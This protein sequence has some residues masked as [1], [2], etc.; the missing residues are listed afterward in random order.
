M[1]RT[2]CSFSDTFL[3]TPYS[4]LRLSTFCCFCY[5]SEKG[6]LFPTHSKTSE[7]FFSPLIIIMTSAEGE[8]T[9]GFSE[10]S[11]NL[12]NSLKFE[13]RLPS[14]KETLQLRMEKNWTQ[15]NCSLLSKEL[16]S[17]KL[18]VTLVT[19]VCLYSREVE[20]R[21]SAPSRLETLQFPES[22]EQ[23]LCVITWNIL[24]SPIL[25]P[26]LYWY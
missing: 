26:I 9:E 2:N 1:W 16:N 13:V 18:F 21:G 22:N 24:H 20:P 12:E 6:I 11:L 17:G 19:E 25:P 7:D 8:R 5:H 14:S 10:N 3:S 23:K 15:R 4:H